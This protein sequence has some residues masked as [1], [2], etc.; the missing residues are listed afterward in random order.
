MLS[1]PPQV[2]SVSG[3]E[4]LFPWTGTL[5]CMVCLTPQFLPVYPHASV[6]PGLPAPT[7]PR[8]LSILAIHLPL[9]LVWMNVSSL[10]PYLSDFHNV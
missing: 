8:V 10:T 2:F 7:L 6:L 3:F 4:A 5:G 9:L 1:Y